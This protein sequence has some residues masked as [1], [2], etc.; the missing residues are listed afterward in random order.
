MLQIPAEVIMKKI[1]MN[2]EELFAQF[3]FSSNDM[4]FYLDTQTGEILPV[5]EFSDLDGGE[6][7]KELIDEN[8]ERFIMFPEQDS[9]RGYDD[10]VDFANSLNNKKLQD[11]LEIALKGR[12]AFRR[13]KDILLDYPEERASWFAFE[14]KQQRERFEEWFEDEEIE[15]VDKNG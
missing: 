9:R 13:F 6:E 2:K 11:K 1:K 15:L 12:G 3:E 7:T 14:E 8:P 4:I 10:M 5:S